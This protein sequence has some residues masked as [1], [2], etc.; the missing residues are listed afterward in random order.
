M[1]TILALIIFSLFAQAPASA[2]VG[3]IDLHTHVF[4]DQGI[5]WF[6]G[7]FNEA[8][9]SKSWKT[10]FASQINPETLDKS[11]LQ[12]VVAAL[13]AFPLST[14]SRRDA[15][16]HQ[17]ASARTF[18]A[19]HPNWVL[20]RSSQETRAAIAQGKKV[21]VLSLE[22]ADGVLETEA[23]LHEFIDE[24][25]ICI[26]TPIHLSDDEV[27]GAAFLRSYHV[28][29]D[30][31]A[32]LNPLQHGRDVNGILLNEKGLTRGGLALIKKLIARHVWIDLS[33]SSDLSQ[34]AI[35]ALLDEK[36]LP[37]LYTHTV[38]RKYYKAERGI[39]P[40]QLKLVKKSGGIIGV[41][42]SEEELAGT[43]PLL[44][45]DAFMR[46]YDEFVDAFGSS[47]QVMIGSD[48]NGGVP[49]LRPTAGSG[50][51]LDKIGLQNIAQEA[52]LWTILKLR[53]K[54]A[55]SRFDEMLETFLRAWERV[56]K[57]N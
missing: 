55:P 38:L 26:V 23:D 8:L 41:L 12:I 15:I 57:A 17:V 14:V 45:F 46:Q 2:D 32:A 10:R 53:S 24:D 9:A 19:G 18:V 40:P 42:P 51:S 43:D 7:S 31:F 49:H 37:F 20:S 48:F 6:R 47:S 13:Y 21:M 30:P 29:S 52:D 4:M 56:S 34:K 44:G 27:G 39:S 1:K 50:T 35:A 11:G 16:R 54:R 22:G 25:G 28:F 3:S 5:P 36:S 33:H